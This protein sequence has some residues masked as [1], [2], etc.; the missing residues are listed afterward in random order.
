MNF[1]FLI[2]YNS[3][4]RRLSFVITTCVRTCQLAGKTFTRS[5]AANRVRRISSIIGDFFKKQK[6]IESR[7]R[8]NEC[9]SYSV[10]SSFW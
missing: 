2:T 8:R 9:K 5:F 3:D 4:K 1:V 10:K 7:R 6:N